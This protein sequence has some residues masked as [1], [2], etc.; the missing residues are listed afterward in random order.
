MSHDLRLERLLDATPDEVFDAFLDPRAQ[1]QWMQDDDGW[2]V[3]TEC[4]CR[5]GGRWV[6]AFGPP[7]AEPFRE[8]NEFTELDPPV[9]VAYT[10]TFSTPDGTSFDTA[11]VVTFEARAAKTLMTIVQTGFPDAAIRDDH[12][13]GWPG[14]IDRL[15][16]VVA[17]RRLPS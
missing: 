14:F 17:E 8:L 9:R 12:Q 6:V 3:T 7:G 16:Q 11:V 5:V 2:V 1:V 15:E 4:D 13:G 10:S